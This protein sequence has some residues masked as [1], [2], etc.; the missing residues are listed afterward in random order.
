MARPWGPPILLQ[1]DYVRLPIEAKTALAHPPGVTVNT[2]AEDEYSM[3]T[4]ANSNHASRRLAICLAAALTV[5]SAP[6]TASAQNGASPSDAFGTIAGGA[7]GGTLGFFGGALLG[8]AG[9][10]YEICWEIVIGAI[11]GQ[12]LGVP[13]GAHVGNQ[14]R[15]HLPA[16][17]GASLL[18]VGVGIVGTSA[19]ESE[20]FYIVS[21]V[22]QLVAVTLTE[23][24]TSPDVSVTAGPQ[25]VGDDV[26]V[27]ITIQW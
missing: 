23:L 25:L 27:G 20:N 10:C 7:V 14:G 1:T 2:P 16:T 15:G 26:G 24:K 19:F 17:L 22:A 5:L 4:I 11:G 3:R 6:A 9:D 8:S 12:A 13:L 18:S 21:M